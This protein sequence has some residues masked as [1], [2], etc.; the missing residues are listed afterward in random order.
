MAT[1]LQ[2]PKELRGPALGEWEETKRVF[3]PG[4]GTMYVPLPFAAITGGKEQ[5]PKYLWRGEP[6]EGSVEVELISYYQALRLGPVQF[7]ALMRERLTPKGGKLLGKLET[8]R[9]ANYETFYHLF[10]VTLDEDPTV[11]RYGA[12]ARTLT[13]NGGLLFAVTHADQARVDELAKAVLATLV[14]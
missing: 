8:L 9:V 14:V 12:Y 3:L 5:S 6:G 10:Q 13:R 2:N 4:G 7:D 11:A 1:R